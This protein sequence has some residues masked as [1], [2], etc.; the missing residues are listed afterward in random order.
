MIITS[1][2]IFSL[3]ITVILMGSALANAEVVIVE[4]DD[5]RPPPYRVPD[6]LTNAV[7]GVTFTVATTTGE[8]T[9]TNWN[10]VEPIEGTFPS[11]GDFVFGKQIGASMATEYC[12]QSSFESVPGVLRADFDI[13][14]NFVSID[15]IDRNSADIGRLR[16][17]NA[18]G[19]LLETFTANLSGTGSFVTASITRA[20]ADIAYVL[21]AGYPETH[22]PIK[23]VALDHFQ[24]EANPPVPTLDFFGMELGNKWRYV[25][26]RQ[27]QPISVERKVTAINK[28]SFSVPVFVDEIKE[29]GVFVGT[30]YYES[31]GEQLKLWGSSIKDKGVVYDLRFSQGLVVAW[32]PLYVGDN[33]YSTATAT[34]VQY[35]GYTF[36]VSLMANVVG[37]E[38]MDLDFGTFEAYKINYT[39]TLRG[40]NVYNSDSFTWWVLPYLGVVKDKHVESTSILS[41][42]SIG[43][44]IIS[45]TSDAD[46]DGLTDI[47]EILLH[48]T[49]WRSADTDSDGID[50]GI[51]VSCGSDPTDAHSRCSYGL[52][53]ILLLLGK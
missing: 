46:T 33:N 10:H 2:K 38:T 9:S 29:N 8:P 27:G 6:E 35:P 52:P 12:F 14:T 21:A 34:I 13:P 25:G 39:L 48:G 24:F 28:S 30:E 15:I 3:I 50:D 47:I 5:F 37:L 40:N 44:G 41:T 23:S 53:W 31:K 49:N 36:N 43:S 18:S 26:T 45:E 17:F 42:F 16:A 1:H 51:E 32:A 7:P 22:F 4:P 19:Y 20:K 11:T